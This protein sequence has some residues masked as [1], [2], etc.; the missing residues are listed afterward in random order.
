M[1]GM[2]WIDM[3]QDRERWRAL[4][5]LIAKNRSAFH[6]DPSPWSKQVSK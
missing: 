1:W 2:E 5:N 3:N 6:K 4:V